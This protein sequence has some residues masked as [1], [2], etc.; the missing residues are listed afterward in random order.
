MIGVP[1]EL[2]RGFL[3]EE[4]QVLG[5]NPVVVLS[6]GLWRRRFGADRSIIGRDVIM[7]NAKYTVVGVTAAGF[8]G[9]ERGFIS[10]FWAPLAMADQIMPDLHTSLLRNDRHAQWVMLIARLKSGVSQR[11]ALTGR[12]HGAAAYR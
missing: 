7:S 3:P 4:D 2:G 6:D 9:M 1:M 8:H 10:D 5:K 12:E 11:Q